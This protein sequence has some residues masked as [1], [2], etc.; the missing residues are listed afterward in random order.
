MKI[1]LIN[2][3]LGLSNKDLKF[4]LK[5]GHLICINLTH[6]TELKKFILFTFILQFFSYLLKI[7]L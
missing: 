5:N 7:I 3:V 4:K 2:K 6:K 1:I